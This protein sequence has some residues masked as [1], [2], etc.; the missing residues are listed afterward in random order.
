MIITLTLTLKKKE[1]RKEK[2][3]DE[4]LRKRG[5]AWGGDRIT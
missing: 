4:K 2:M 5:G 1:G 3:R